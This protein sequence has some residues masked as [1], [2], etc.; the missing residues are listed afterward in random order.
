MQVT[1]LFIQTMDKNITVNNQT[2]FI[3][4]DIPI[5][6][7]IN[8][9]IYNDGKGEIEYNTYVD[10][11]RKTPNKTITSIADFQLCI[12]LWLTTKQQHEKDNALAQGL[13]IDN[14]NKLTIDADKEKVQL[15]RTAQQLL[16]A[17][18]WQV[19]KYVE[20][21]GRGIDTSLTKE[22]FEQL[23]TARDAARKQINKIAS[24]KDPQ[25]LLANQ[26]AQQQNIKTQNMKI[27]QEQQAIIKNHIR[28]QSI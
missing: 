17:T 16:V 10:V 8:A 4:G 25:I 5:D 3:A 19:T 27:L 2:I 15:E 12:D 26:S 20:Q 23:C 6:K 24:I 21:Q 7:N 28:I 11:G 18:D 9:V 1:Q 22:E 13:K 14:K